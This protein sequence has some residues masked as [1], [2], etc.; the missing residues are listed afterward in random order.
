MIRLIVGICLAG[1][2]LLAEE[3]VVKVRGV[4]GDK[5]EV[6]CAL[7]SVADGFP[8]DAAK[9]RQIWLKPTAGAAECR[10]TDVAPGRYAVAVAVDLNGNHKTYTN[11]VGIPKEDWGVSNNVRPKLRA[12]KFEEAAFTVK[13][14]EAA[15]LAIEVGR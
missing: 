15:T 4:K 13:P 5:G 8:M 12:P 7:H 10:F 9:A 11:L 3:V 6:G 2:W 14:G 1:G